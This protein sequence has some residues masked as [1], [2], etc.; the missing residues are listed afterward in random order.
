MSEW[1]LLWILGDF[2]F[3]SSSLRPFLAADLISFYAAGAAGSI[4]VRRDAAASSFLA[5]ASCFC[6]CL[7][8]VSA[9]ASCGTLAT[10]LLL[11]WTIFLKL[12]AER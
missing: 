12:P 3:S 5:A 6:C 9:A 8:W 1:G 10:L 7:L 11:G 4:G 2:P